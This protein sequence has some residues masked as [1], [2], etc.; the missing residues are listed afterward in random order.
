MKSKTE[1]NKVVDM[2]KELS[3]LG[4]SNQEVSKRIGY[5]RGSLSNIITGRR[6]MSDRFFERFVILYD[7]VITPNDLSEENKRLEEIERQL[8][9]RLAN[10]K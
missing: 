9:L 6:R 7:G 2:F 8:D 3:A 5:G 4:I 10:G 1:Q